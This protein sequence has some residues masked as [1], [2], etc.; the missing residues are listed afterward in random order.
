MDA[1]DRFKQ[2]LV[3]TLVLSILFAIAI[4][5]PASTSFMSV[6][7]RLAYSYLG[8]PVIFVA[9][10][11][12]AA[13][14]TRTRGWAS[15][16]GPGTRI[17]TMLFYLAVSGAIVL[18][19]RPLNAWIAV[20]QWSGITSKYRLVTLVPP[21]LTPQFLRSVVGSPISEE[22]LFRGWLLTWLRQRELP[23]VGFGRRFSVD[24]TNLLVSLS[25]GL[26]HLISQGSIY[27]MIGV[28]VISL[29]FGAARIK[30]GGL[31]L[32]MLCH[33]LVNLVNAT[34]LVWRA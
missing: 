24:G 30:S 8:I 22:L 4:T 34:F 19:S 3:P 27:T 14:R 1:L 13:W 5:V 16:S 25:F 29:V 15:L 6:E 11:C 7:A 23:A 28:A 33:A 31:L 10:A 32:P 21:E 12:A 18:A 20:L 17:G 9:V 2:L 26:M